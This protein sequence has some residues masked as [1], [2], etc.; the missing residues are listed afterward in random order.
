VPGTKSKKKLATKPGGKT[1]QIKCKTDNALP[2]DRLNDFQKG[3]KKL[4][5]ENLAKLQESIITQGF[6]APIFVWKGEEG[7]WWILD[8][9]SRL[10]ALQELAKAGWKIPPV[11]VSEI[12]AKTRK[13]AK[14][15]LLAIV[16]AYGEFNV[17]GI[18]R[19]I[20]DLNIDELIRTTNLEGIDLSEL[21]SLTEDIQEEVER[22]LEKL[23]T[24]N[25]CPKCG[26]KW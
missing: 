15:K 25:E 8:G 2:M 18:L 20:S 21:T 22:E 19:F 11:P 9:H 26:Y 5:P 7:K 6:C 1:I 12:M 10:K 17:N 13:E 4:P 16:S 24:T 23:K 3:L 14:E